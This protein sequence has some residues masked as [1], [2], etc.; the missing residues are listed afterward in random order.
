MHEAM[1]SQESILGGMW[2]VRSLPEESGAPLPNF[3]QD[4]RTYMQ[5]YHQ[6]QIS[7][8]YG[9]DMNFLTLTILPHL[10]ASNTMY[11]CSLNHK[12]NHHQQTHNRHP[13]IS[14]L[15][16]LIFPSSPYHGFVGQPINCVHMCDW[17]HFLQTGCPH[18]QAL[19]YLTPE[20]STALRHKPNL[21]ENVAAFL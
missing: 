2:G 20:L 10:N 3:A 5:Q 8:P 17:Q 16:P 14:S 9:A 7:L 15:Q 11:H 6:Q 12:N 1:H 19:S 13:S 18:V 4:I 21:L